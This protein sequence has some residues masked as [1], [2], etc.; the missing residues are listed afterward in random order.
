MKIVWFDQQASADE[1]GGKGFRL[2]RLTQA[3]LPVPPGF[4]IA[5]S[6]MDHITACVIEAALMRLGCKP[7]AVR[8]SAVGEDTATASFAGIYSSRLNIVTAAGVMEALDEIRRSAVGPAAVAYCRK[9]GISQP[10]GMAAVVQESLIP[11]ASGVLFMKDPLDG[12]RRIVIEGSWGLGEA[13]VAGRVTPDRWVL[14]SK[15][16]LVSSRIS[17]K[18]VAIIPNGRGTTEVQIE[19]ARRRLPCLNENSLCRL[20]ELADAC[21]Q[22]FGAPQDIEWATALNRV[23]LLQSRPITR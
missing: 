19:P 2:C 13:V 7:V 9:R 12:S 10:P 18:D 14:S 8:S 4:C 6:A 3:A 21:E 17:D 23:W 11:D 16:A 5:V 22:L 20:I 1:V 15:G